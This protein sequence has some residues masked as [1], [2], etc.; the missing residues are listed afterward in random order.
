MSEQQPPE[1]T[2]I[3]RPANARLP[4]PARDRRAVRPR[5]TMSAP[6]TFVAG[7]ALAASLLGAAAAVA[8]TGAAVVARLLWPW[9][10]AAGR[11]LARPPVPTPSTRPSRAVAPGRHPAHVA[12]WLGPGVRVSYTHVEIY[13]PG[14]R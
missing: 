13:W 9:T 11:D 4:V 8:V 2:D 5:D 14:E 6:S 10:T 3:D 12:G 1:P 7:P